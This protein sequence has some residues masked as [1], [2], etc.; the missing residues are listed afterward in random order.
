[1]K[2]ITSIYFSGFLELY[3][4][5]D[6]KFLNLT[7]KI[8]LK[9]NLYLFLTKIKILKKK[10]SSVLKILFDIDYKIIILLKKKRTKR[11]TSLI[12]VIING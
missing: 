11:I 2:I 9:L 10:Y 8:D 6:E 5:V 3:L 4:N 1:M 7:I 12:I